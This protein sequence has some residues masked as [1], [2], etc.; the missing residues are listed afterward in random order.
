MVLK[1]A[2]IVVL[3]AEIFLSHQ[4]GSSSGM[5]SRWLADRTGIRESFLRSAA[6]V[7]IF[8]VLAALGTI[9]FGWI[10]LIVIAVWAVL[11]EVTKPLLR[12]QRHCSGKDILLNLAGTGIG[13][14]IALIL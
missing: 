13:G 9:G 8:A 2:V 14:A 4:S 5:E 3:L 7:L 6:H 10:G 11:D 1:I 12:N